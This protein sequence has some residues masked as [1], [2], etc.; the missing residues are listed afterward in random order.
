MINAS[1]LR[2]GNYY[3]GGFEI[4]GSLKAKLKLGDDRIFKMTLEHLLVL[5]HKENWLSSIKPIPLTHDV[6]I[7]IGA[8]VV[9][10]AT[11]RLGN[12]EIDIVTGIVDNGLGTINEGVLFLY[13]HKFQNLIFDLT[14]KELQYNG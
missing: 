8:S 5:S 4:T 9:G 3:E 6:M 1:E 11:Y 2:I 13:L 10:T 7:S 14:G 12:F